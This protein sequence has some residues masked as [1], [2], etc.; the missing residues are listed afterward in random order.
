MFTRSLSMS[1][2]SDS[3]RKTA[4][5]GIVDARSGPGLFPAAAPNLVHVYSQNVESE[6]IIDFGSNTRRSATAGQTCSCTRRSL[7]L[8]VTRT[9]L[10]FSSTRSSTT[11]LTWS[12]GSD[13]ALPLIFSSLRNRLEDGCI[14]VMAIVLGSCGHSKILSRGRCNLFYL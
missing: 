4:S 1:V 14:W 9:L 8:R 10:P 5:P 12:P 7:I 11:V 2:V 3:F 6:K 13:S